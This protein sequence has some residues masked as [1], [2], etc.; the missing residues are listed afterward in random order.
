MLRHTNESVDSSLRCQCSVNTCQI[1]MLLPHG[2]TFIFST[3]TWQ[4]RVTLWPCCWL[5]L[6]VCMPSTHWAPITRNP[7]MI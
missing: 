7:Y 3:H 1:V 2:S 4:A 5:D 6:F